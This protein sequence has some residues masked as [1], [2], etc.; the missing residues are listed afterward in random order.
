MS[1]EQKTKA[2]R[3]PIPGTKAFGSIMVDAIYQK[4]T[5]QI[6][7]SVCFVAIVFTLVNLLVDILYGIID[8][9]VKASLQKA[10]KPLLEETKHAF[11][12]IFGK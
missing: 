3:D 2:L 9:R 10:R 11:A 5:P 1:A 12:R 8:P 4:D 6:L 7:G